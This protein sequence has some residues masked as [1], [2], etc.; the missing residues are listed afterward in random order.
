[1][2]QYYWLKIII[3]F[4][5][6]TSDINN[7]LATSQR[8]QRRTVNLATPKYFIDVILDFFINKL[9]SYK[10]QNRL[11]LVGKMAYFREW[12]TTKIVDLSSRL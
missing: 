9:K 1:M 5:G 12:P 2:G 7:N 3:F 8:R 11:I 4:S 10:H 6:D